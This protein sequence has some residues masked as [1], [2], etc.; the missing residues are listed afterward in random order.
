VN[1]TVQV[2]VKVTDDVCVGVIVPVREGVE[3]D[4]AARGFLVFVGVK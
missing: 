1:V 2:G 4:V 3:V